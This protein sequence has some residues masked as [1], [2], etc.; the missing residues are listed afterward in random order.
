VK[1]A[2]SETIGA[3]RGRAGTRLEVM[4]G[5]LAEP[6]PKRADV[7]RAQAEAGASLPARARRLASMTAAAKHS[8]PETTKT[9]S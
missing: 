9:P 8:A 6:A 1:P 3:E 5:G 4:D 2:V 7:R